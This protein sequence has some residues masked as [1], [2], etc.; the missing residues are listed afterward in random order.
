MAS[1]DSNKNKLNDKHKNKVDDDGFF[2]EKSY[3]TQKSYVKDGDKDPVYYNK[4]YRHRKDKNDTSE[5]ES[6]DE[7]PCNYLPPRKLFKRP[8][9][10][11]PP[12]PIFQP[13][14]LPFYD[15]SS[16]SD[17]D[18]K[19]KYHHHPV[20]GQDIP[21]YALPHHKINDNSDSS[22]DDEK[23]IRKKIIRNK[24]QLKKK[25]NKKYRKDPKHHLNKALFYYYNQNPNY[26]PYLKPCAY[27]VGPFDDLYG[28]YYDPVPS[29]YYNT[30]NR[31]TNNGFKIP[32]INPNNWAWNPYYENNTNYNNEIDHFAYNNP[33]YPPIG[34]PT[35]AYVGKPFAGG[36]NKIWDSENTAYHRC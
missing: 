19:P 14:Y 16:E 22:C 33:I 24:K 17:C 5:D 23:D 20:V 15:E 3:R 11:P 1:D 28:S 35:Q 7:E 2:E 12:P 8:K 29:I 18:D 32:R 4:R 31:I 10:Y 36:K 25:T 13:P 21:D 27:K 30:C 26:N 9:F 6:S 34:I